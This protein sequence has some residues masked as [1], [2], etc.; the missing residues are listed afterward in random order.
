M[1][2]K[3]VTFED[4]SKENLKGSEP[5]A[6]QI[7]KPTET[8]NYNE[9]KLSYNYGTP[10]EPIVQDLYLELPKVTAT[11]IKRKEEPA[12]GKNGAYTKVSESMML[13]F[14]LANPETRN[15][16]LKALDKLDEVHQAAC[17]ILGSCKAKLKMYDFDPTRTGGMFKNPI[18][19]HRDEGTGEKVKGKNPNLWIKLRNSSYNRTLFTDLTGKAVDWKL[20]NNVNIEMVPL[21]HI[22]KV[23]IGAKASLQMFL[24]SAI[25]LKI[26]AVGS[27]SR[28]VSTMERLKSKYGASL[29]DQVEAQLASLRMERQDALEAQGNFRNDPSDSNDFGT[30]HD[31]SPQQN[32]SQVSLPEFLAG[33]PTMSQ[34]NLHSNQMQQTSSLPPLAHETSGPSL[35]LNVKK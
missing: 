13:I 26:A 31:L 20:L 3:L 21:L 5:A 15:D 34:S 19:W 33:A 6:Q 2:N 14:D 35:R 27:E 17:N 4:F 11:G 28:Q 32:S 30:M 25:I 1:S 24:N 29:A 18:Y 22:E 10:N 9:I 16:C 12:T 23:Y 8:I 7:K